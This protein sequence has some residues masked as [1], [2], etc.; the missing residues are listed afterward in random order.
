MNEQMRAEA[1]ARIAVETEK[2]IR[3]A[4]TRLAGTKM[5]LDTGDPGYELFHTLSDAEEAVNETIADSPWAALAA[6]LKTPA[7]SNGDKVAAGALSAIRERIEEAPRMGAAMEV[8]AYEVAADSG[9]ADQFV[10][11][12]YAA[13]DQVAPDVDFDTKSGAEWDLWLALQSAAE[14]LQDRFDKITE[15][16]RL[17]LELPGGL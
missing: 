13:R 2:T 12:L 9:V 3:A 8:L 14:E 6:D 11:V 5:S 17:G 16:L 15:Q 1:C 10:S 7:S 4:I